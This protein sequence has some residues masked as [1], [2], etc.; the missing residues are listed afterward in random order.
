MV[1]GGEGQVKRVELG[2]GDGENGSNPK[3]DHL[4]G[5]SSTLIEHHSHAVNM[6][7]VANDTAKA[8]PG[9]G[10]PAGPT[11]ILEEISLSPDGNHYTGIFTLDAYDTAGNQVAHL[12]G[13]ISATRVDLDTTVPDL[14]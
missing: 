5:Q 3:L 10:N 11:L 2:C 14:L 9:I 8:P 4:A 7:E 13:T 1:G 6:L 12:V